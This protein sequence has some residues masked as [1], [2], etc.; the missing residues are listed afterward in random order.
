[1]ISYTRDGFFERN[2]MKRTIIGVMLVMACG[3]I[4][5]GMRFGGPPLPQHPSGRVPYGE[6]ED[7]RRTQ[8]ETEAMQRRAVEQGLDPNADPV[9]VLLG[10]WSPRYRV[11][12]EK[13]AQEA[14]MKLGLQN[15]GGLNYS[16]NASRDLTLS[17]LYLQE[18]MSELVAMVDATPPDEYTIHP[19][20]RV[21][22]RPSAQIPPDAEHTIMWPGRGVVP[23]DAQGGPVTTRL[24][25]MLGYDPSRNMLIHIAG[26]VF[27]ITLTKGEKRAK[28]KLLNRLNRD[29]PRILAIL[30]TQEGITGLFTAAH[31]AEAQSR[32]NRTR[33]VATLGAV[34]GQQATPALPLECTISFYLNEH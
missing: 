28:S 21:C 18:H 31:Q 27:G 16:R 34:L 29:A 20:Q 33:L 3:G 7:K 12:P 19:N 8:K 4:A 11:A 24:M 14:A 15:D 22:G 17:L 1:M 2:K 5:D 25:N 26:T 32:I 23:P 10:M 6:G 9:R 30:E 13:V